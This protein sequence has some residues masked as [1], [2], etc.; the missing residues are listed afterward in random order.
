V[1]IELADLLRCPAHH[2][3]SHLV[4]ATGEML[5]R[6]IT[7]GVVACPVCQAEFRI[8]QGIVR[9]GAPDQRPPSAT[10]PEPHA[11]EAFLGVAG[12]GGYVALVGSAARAAPGLAG[13]LSGVH[14]IG[15]NAPPDVSPSPTLSL[16]E[17]PDLIPV[18]TASVRGVVVGGERAGEPWL[19]EAAR[20]VLPGLRMVVLS[21]EGS[22]EGVARMATGPGVWVGVKQSG[23]GKREA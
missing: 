18:R 2:A 9:F 14:L 3:E 17:S 7:H 16:L 4:V 19:G 20:V 11:V 22:A 6:S 8:A 15:I 23:T 10:L 13:P 12:P 1:F 21:N 5:G